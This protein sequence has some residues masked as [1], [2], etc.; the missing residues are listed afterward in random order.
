[1]NLPKNMIIGLVGNS[2]AGK[3]TV[4]G[5][6]SRRGFS[7]IDCDVIARK[8]A[9]NED[10]LCELDDRFPENLRNPDG[11][12]DRALTASVIF[13]DS[14][15][16]GLYNRIIFPYII[17]NVIS[18]IKQAGGDVLLDAPTLFEA[19]LDI[20]CTAVVSVTAER[21]ICWERIRQRD[22]L[23]PEQAENRLLSQKNAEFFK[24]FSDYNIENNG[25]REQLF[26]SADLVIDE[27]KGKK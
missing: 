3:S 24:R 4:C 22:N 11:S 10:F 12:L 8:V 25:T 23:S 20:I 13:T 14:E 18:G 5:M 27:L 15:K 1:M 9:D 19:G 17:Y 16:R 2:G 7:V 6:F 26:R 21:G